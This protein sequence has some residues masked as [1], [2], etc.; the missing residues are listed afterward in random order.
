MSFIKTLSFVI[1]ESRDWSVI[2]ERTKI[3]PQ[4]NNRKLE[5][6]NLDYLLCLYSDDQSTEDWLDCGL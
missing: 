2:D 4:H 3:L 5:A 6:D 1:H